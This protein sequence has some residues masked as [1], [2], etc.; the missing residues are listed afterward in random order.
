MDNT[1]GLTPLVVCLLSGLETSSCPW[2]VW[3]LGMI[4]QGVELGDELD[5]EYA[6][7]H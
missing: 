1:P 5:P 2:S 3:S 7:Y 4:S 6:S